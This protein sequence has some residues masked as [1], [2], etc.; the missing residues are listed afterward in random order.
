MQIS[1]RFLFVGGGSVGHIAPAVA[2]WEELSDTHSNS[3]AL[4]ICS[5]RSDETE[6]LE[7]EGVSYIPMPLPRNVWSFIGSIQKSWK[8]VRD[9]KPSI[10]FSKGGSLSVPLCVCAWILGIPIVIHE[11]DAILGRANAFIARFCTRVCLGMRVT[12]SSIG[13][14]HAVVTGNP[15]R[16][17]VRQGSREEG[18]RITGLRGEKPVLL[19]MGGSQGAKA[20]NDIVWNLLPKILEKYEVVHITGRGKIPNPNLQIPNAK[21]YWSIEF[22]TSE[23]PHIYALAD[24]ALSRA[25]AGSI[26]ELEA[27]NIPAIL[28]PL[29]GVPHPHQQNNADSVADSSMFIAIDQTE[30]SD[31]L[32][33]TLKALLEQHHSKE[34]VSHAAVNIVK[35]IETVLAKKQKHA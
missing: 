34:D 33:P 6:F 10:V 14:P 19:V 7:A 13:L 28:V 4:F 11:S 21:Q 12:E 3:Q 1:S 32:L 17:A 8:I 23:L 31:T 15:V 22:C 29:T 27:N 18:K 9:F 35:V 26:A 24:V 2:V 5:Q 20:L 25:G 16:R 30:L